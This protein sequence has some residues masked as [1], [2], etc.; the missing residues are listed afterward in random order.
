MASHNKDV[1]LLY[2]KVLKTYSQVSLWRIFRKWLLSNYIR[3]FIFVIY[4]ISI[5]VLII[6][7]LFNENLLYKMLDLSAIFIIEIIAIIVSAKSIINF[8]NIDKYKDF[9][10]F[11]KENW[12]SLKYLLF[13]EHF[14]KQNNIS[15]ED[16]NALISFLERILEREFAF[17]I[18]WK[19]VLSF[20]TSLVSVLGSWNVASTFYKGKQDPSPIIALTFP[21]IF[22]IVVGAIVLIIAF[23]IMTIKIIW[24]PEKDKT[25]EIL[26]FLKLL[27]E[28]LY[29]KG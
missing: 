10:L 25:K 18:D 2:Q 9:A 12:L 13:R 6:L 7:F 15:K 5:P 26:L 11:H 24:K 19:F 20:I 4:F 28:E 14:L 22:L 16:I 17:N 29:A 3:I 21:L 8:Y 27:R 23:G 1:I